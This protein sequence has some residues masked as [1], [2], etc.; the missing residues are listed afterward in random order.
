MPDGNPNDII[1][2]VKFK[3]FYIPPLFHSNQSSKNYDKYNNTPQK[4]NA[5]GNWYWKQQQ[6]QK[7]QCKIDKLP[8]R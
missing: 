7:D 5:I 3:P 1:E 2:M 6:Q 4:M 8:K